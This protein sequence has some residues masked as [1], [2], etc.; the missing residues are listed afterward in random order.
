MIAS[1]WHGMLVSADLEEAMELTSMQR[2]CRKAIGENN[3]YNRS[4]LQNK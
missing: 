4:L 2:G 1:F 3:L